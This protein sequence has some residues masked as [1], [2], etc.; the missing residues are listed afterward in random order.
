[1]QVAHQTVRGAII[2]A[3]GQIK[4]KGQKYCSHLA[5]QRR[6]A[7]MRHLIDSTADP[8][9]SAWD[10]SFAYLHY[11]FLQVIVSHL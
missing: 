10:G 8:S 3:K 1:M 11:F 2:T 6:A 7:R 9:T 4:A 5:T